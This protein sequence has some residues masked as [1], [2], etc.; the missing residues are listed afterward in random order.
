VSENTAAA[1][2]RV[3]GKGAIGSGKI[4]D[5]VRGEKRKE[6]GVQR[7]ESAAR[8]RKSHIRSW[9]RVDGE[10]RANKTLGEKKLATTSGEKVSPGSS[11]NEGAGWFRQGDGISPGE[12]RIPACGRGVEK[13]PSLQTRCPLGERKG[14]KGFYPYSGEKGGNPISDGGANVQ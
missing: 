5:R 10:G 6:R 1:V 7:V 11:D 8:V 9:M 14:E 12:E 3:T 13:T 4:V 2:S